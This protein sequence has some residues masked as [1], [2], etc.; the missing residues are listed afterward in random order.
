[1]RDVYRENEDEYIRLSSHGTEGDDLEKVGNVEKLSYLI[2][3]LLIMMIVSL[4]SLRVSSQHL[5]A[6]LS[7]YTVALK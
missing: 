2:H 6:I 4:I 3:V 5:V 7:P 1:M